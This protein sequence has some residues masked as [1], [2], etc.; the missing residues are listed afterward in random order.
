MALVT[1][2][3]QIRWG[4]AEEIAAG[5]AVLTMT[6]IIYAENDPPISSGD[7]LISYRGKSV[8]RYRASEQFKRGHYSPSISGLTMPWNAH[9]TPNF[10]YSLFQGVTRSTNKLTFNSDSADFSSI[11]SGATITSSFPHVMTI[12]REDATT[13]AWGHVLEGAVV[14]S[15]TISG[16][17]SSA[18]TCSV[19]LV[20]LDADYNATV[21]PAAEAFSTFG[22]IHTLV[23]LDGTSPAYIDFFAGAPPVESFSITISNGA[24]VKAYNSAAPRQIDFADF[25]DVSGSITIASDRSGNTIPAFEGYMAAMVAGTEGAF[26]IASGELDPADTHWSIAVNARIS[27]GIDEDEGDAHNATINFVGVQNGATEDIQ[28]VTNS[29]TSGTDAW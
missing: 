9:Q 7:S 2:P 18:I 28:I 22:K 24:H 14:S 5:T 1:T 16:D 25:I 29:N 12:T 21:V 8:N 11:L 10:L 27:E 17:T 4:L 23:E 13:G 3:A 20:G 19:D 15:M 6:K 26:V